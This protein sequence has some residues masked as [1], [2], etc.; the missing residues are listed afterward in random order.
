MFSTP[1]TDNTD[2]TDQAAVGVAVDLNRIE[3]EAFT[4]PATTT[5]SI[6]NGSRSF[7]AWFR[8]R[9]PN[10]LPAVTRQ[11]LVSE[12]IGCRGITLRVDSPA[13]VVGQIASNTNGCD[14]NPLPTT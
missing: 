5:W 11:V 14:G 6:A 4:A 7:E 12:A 10:G 8:L 1:S 3:N 9:N 13:T 2:R